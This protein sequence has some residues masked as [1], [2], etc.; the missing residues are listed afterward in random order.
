MKIGVKAFV[1]IVLVAL[2][3]LPLLSGF[4]RLP[5]DLSPTEIG[6]FLRTLGAYWYDIFKVAI[7]K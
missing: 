5:Q 1:L 3:T 2:L 7:G 4:S 6:S